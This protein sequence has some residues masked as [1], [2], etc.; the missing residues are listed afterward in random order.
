MSHSTLQ[1]DPSGRRAAAETDAELTEIQGLLDQ[2]T[3]YLRFSPGLERGF[4]LHVQGRALDLLSHG[5]WVLIFFY[6]GLGVA[7]WLQVRAY[8][9]PALLA[10]NVE[11]WLWVYLAEGLVV[12]LLLFLPR[13]PALNEMYPLYTGVAAFIALASIII[14]TSAFPDPYLNQH[15]SYVV[16]F[17][18][19]IIYGIGGLRVFPAVLICAL[20]VGFSWA[21]IRVFDLWFSFGHFS[22]YVLLANVVGVLLCY[23]LEHRDRV[24]YLQS[25]LLHLE[26]GKLDA[27]SREL[28][29]LSREDVL[30]GL[31]NRR[32]FNETFQQEWDRAR[33]EQRPLA[34]IFIDVDHF[35]P[36]NDNH[37]HLEG[38]RV[39]AEVGRALKGVLR[40]PGDLA[41]R[42]GGEEFVILLPN[43]PLAGAVEV[44]QQVRHA[45]HALHIPHRASSVADHVTA[46]LGVAAV[47]PGNGLRSAQLIARADEAVYAAKAAGRDCIMTVDEQGALAARPLA[48]A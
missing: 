5:W 36:F 23:L 35:K 27:F 1:N 43:T 7:T 34:L 40:R 47:Q 24:M 33:R 25:R 37:G 17:I 19:T 15:S 13:L 39:L 44:A 4:R 22:Q 48:R 21:V 46:S 10:A 29:R 30:T 31:A 32:H 41:A 6:I 16:I 14:A 28:S 2:H 8:S 42:F 11:I 26:K 18:I 12:L 9:D 38:D 3:R 20:A 45:L